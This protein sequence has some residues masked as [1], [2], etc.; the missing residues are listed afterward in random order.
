MFTDHGAPTAVILTLVNTDLETA[1]LSTNPEFLAL[2]QRSQAHTKR[3]ESSPR[4]R[5]T[6]S[7]SGDM[8]PEHRRT[9]GH[10]SWIEN[11][12]MAADLVVST[13]WLAKHLND[14]DVRV[15]DMRGSVVTSQVAPGVEQADYRG[16]RDEYLAGHIPG[17]VYVDWTADIIDPD[18]PVRPGRASGSIRRGDGGAGHRR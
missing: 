7:S 4:Q 2:I 11:T 3:R 12:I 13:E 6:A 10:E 16:A 18:D 15:V 1:A 8:R 9:T 17:A 14:P 5:C